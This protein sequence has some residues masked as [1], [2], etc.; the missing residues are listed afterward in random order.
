MQIKK[1]ETEKYSTWDW[2]F[3]KS[4]KYNFENSKKFIGGT[5]E[6]HLQVEHGVITGC[7]IFGDFFGKKDVSDLEVALIG[8]KHSKDEI[9][10]ILSRFDIN[11]Y[12][13]NVDLDELVEMFN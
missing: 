6:V 13:F 5:V 7:R 4:P 1:L 8:E 9:K 3:G 11:E 2:N 12:M 10:N